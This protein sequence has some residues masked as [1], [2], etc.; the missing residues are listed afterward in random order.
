MKRSLSLALA[1]AAAVAVAA[2]L[3]LAPGAASAQ[4]QRDWSRTIVATAEGGFR[5][6]NP[7]AP[8]KVVEFVSLTCPHCRQFAASGSPELVQNYVRSGRVSFE[9]RPFP[10]DAVAEMAAQLNRCAPPANAFAL[11]DA[12][13]ASQDQWIGR[14]EALSDQQI[15]A[16]ERLPEPELRVRV[17]SVT[18][19]DALAARH[20]IPAARVRSCLA[21]EAGAQRVDAIKAAGERL[22]I[23]G[24]P[25]FTINGR[26][27]QNVHDWSALEPLLRAG[28]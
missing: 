11:N 19:L 3:A 25:S 16:L 14:L 8:V 5:M 7:A 27:A 10:L 20:G 6:G 26:V 2:P 21:D 28:R 22:G 18:Q 9:I 24:T 1:A 23:A 17:A 4:A 15:S 13:L 12:I